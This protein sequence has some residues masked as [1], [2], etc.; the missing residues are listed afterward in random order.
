MTHPAQK[1]LAQPPGSTSPTFVDSLTPDENQI[2]SYMWKSCETGP[3][4][5]LSL[6][7][8][9]S[10]T[11]CKCHY[12]GSTLFLSYLKTLSVGPAVVWARDL[13]GQQCWELLRVC[14][15]SCANRCNNSQQ[16]WDPQCIVGRMQPISLCKPCIMS[17]RGPNNVGRAV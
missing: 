16:C 4:V 5:F 3:T 17:V 9:E 15:Q 6:K 2:C 10:L 1:R 13:L 7:R 11:V 12:K 14:W 8:L